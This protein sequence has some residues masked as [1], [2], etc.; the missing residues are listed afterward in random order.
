MSDDKPRV[1]LILAALWLLTF[2]STSQVLIIAPLLPS[3]SRELGVA[4]QW[5]G[6]LIGAYGL[7][8]AIVA[9]IAGPISDKVGRRPILLAGTAIMAVALWGHMVAHSFGALLV[10]RAISGG[11][12]GVLAGAAVAYVGD[13]FPYERR[14]WA[15]GWV[16]S[17]LALGQVLGIPLGTVLAK[18][19]GFQAPFLIFAVL[20]SAAF[21]LVWFAVPQP[22]VA[23]AK[24]V[25][26]R[27]ALQG[28]V[29]LLKR[30]PTAAMASSYALTF[31]GLSLFI[32]YL[33]VWLWDHMQ[34]DEDSVALL[35][36][37]GGLAGVVTNP[38]AGWLSD[39]HGRKIFITGACTVFAIVAV[40]AP[41]V[42]TDFRVVVALFCV[43]MAAA[44]ARTPAQ[45]A[46]VS[47]IVSAKERG[48][49]LSMGSAMGQSGFATGG[50]L[51][52]FLYESVGFVGCA[53][54]SAAAMLST[55]VVVAVFVPE[56]DGSGITQP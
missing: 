48:S 28:Y 25:N 15:N 11:A 29:S 44:A 42:G 24:E 27:K 13:F 30:A 14:G 4:E 21:F 56:P 46:L 32:V 33:P 45:Q 5:G 1:G 41:F 26:V 19:A 23:R 54:G 2:A 17:G 53:F 10:V 40:A 31:G 43:G 49:L 8:A 20:V 36:A 47:S 12:G 50:V 6:L 22:D 55:A 16:M 7:S 34:A 18:R 35:Y 39:R 37:L 51:A 52:G 9:L 38:V 3:I